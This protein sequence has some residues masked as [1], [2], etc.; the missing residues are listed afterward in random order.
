MIEPLAAG[1]ESNEFA[2]PQ[3]VDLSPGIYM[4]QLVDKFG[5]D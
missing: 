4:A 2:R 5:E 3:L 1:G